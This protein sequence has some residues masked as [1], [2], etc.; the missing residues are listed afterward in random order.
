MIA[1]DSNGFTKLCFRHICNLL[2]VIFDF[3]AYL[4]VPSA[5]S[6]KNQTLLVSF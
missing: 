6:D 3:S 1:N 4:S 5:W 2:S